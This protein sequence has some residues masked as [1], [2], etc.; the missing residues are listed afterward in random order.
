MVMVGCSTRNHCRLGQ[1]EIMLNYCWT[2]VTVHPGDGWLVNEDQLNIC[3]PFSMLF[4]WA[5]ELLTDLESCENQGHRWVGRAAVYRTIY[6]EPMI[7]WLF[8]SSPLRFPSLFLAEAMLSWF[9]DPGTHSA[10][11]CF[12]RSQN[13]RTRAPFYWTQCRGGAQR[14]ILTVRPRV[15]LEKCNSDVS[16]L[17]HL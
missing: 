1:L 16:D 7:P 14:K 13:S 3:Q 12:D 9:R 6:I 5:N 17:Y 2:M 4:L 11:W 15:F 8:A 10:F